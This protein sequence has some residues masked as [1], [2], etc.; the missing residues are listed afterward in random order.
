MSERLKIEII[1]PIFKNSIYNH[2]FKIK[3][4]V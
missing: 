4:L 3:F 2:Y 1:K